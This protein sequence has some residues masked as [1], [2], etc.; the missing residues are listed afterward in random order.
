MNDVSTI[1]GCV[2][3]VAL[4]DA[5][6]EGETIIMFSIIPFNYLMSIQT[7]ILDCSELYM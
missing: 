4:G 6:E 1:L 2:D 3:D 5:A 7:V